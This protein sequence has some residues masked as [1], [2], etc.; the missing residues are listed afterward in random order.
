[1]DARSASFALGR[2]VLSRKEPVSDKALESLVGLGSDGV[3]GLL[4]AL[5]TKSTDK[6]VDVIRAIGDTGH[7][8]ATPRIAMYLL[9]GT[10]DRTVSQR[11]A[12]LY[13]IDKF[14]Q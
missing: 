8:E 13:A 1:M 10:K 3:P 7:V 2:F 12:A 11:S 14:G 5:S 9:A 4:E 6:R